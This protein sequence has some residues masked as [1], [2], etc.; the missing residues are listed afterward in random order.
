MAGTIAEMLIGSALQ[1]AGETADLAGSLQKGA[2]LGIQV[3]QTKQARATLENKKQELEMQKYEK[4]GGMFDTAAK[5]PD[6]PAKKAFM[7]QY[8]PKAISALGLEEAFDPAVK[9]M[10]LGD[11]QVASFLVSQIREGNAPISILG[12]AEEAA[13]YA[14]KMNIDQATLAD[15]VK[16]YPEA[17]ADAGKFKTEEANKEKRAYIEAQNAMDKQVQGQDAAPI[18][19]EKKKTRELH[20]TYQAAGGASGTKSR[21]K[22]LEEVRDALKSNKIKFGTIAKNI[23]YGSSL[24]VLART[25]P[26]AKAAIDKIR[27][28]IN[29]KLRTGDPNPTQNQIDQIY[30]QAI[31]PRLDNNANIAK[32]E[33]EIQAEKDAEANALAQFQRAGIAVQT[34][35]DNKPKGE[36]KKKVSEHKTKL[37][38]KSKEDKDRYAN[39]LASKLDIPLSEIRKELGLE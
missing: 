9:E 22:K 13:R 31:D 25:D 15:T 32:L 14:T 39:G 35:S 4:V 37:Q 27:S 12:D 30:N 36:W 33:A 19:E 21:I 17:L 24:E 16:A 7:K 2:A 18:V 38:G 34:P 28:S 8:V 10:L 1:G 5:M 26:D 20:V 29:V 23:P 11:P 6:G 3:E